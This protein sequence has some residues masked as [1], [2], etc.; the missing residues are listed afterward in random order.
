ML[1]MINQQIDMFAPVR[2]K[3]V[4][5]DSGITLSVNEH[6]ALGRQIKV[7]LEFLWDNQWHS[8]DEISESTGVKITSTD[9]Q[10]R[11]LRKEKH[12]GFDIEYKR[13]NNV[14]HYRLN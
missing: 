7:I 10:V 4:Y 9:A 12:G 11:N 2:N 5:F 13:F 6:V 3:M 1:I 8:I 14:A